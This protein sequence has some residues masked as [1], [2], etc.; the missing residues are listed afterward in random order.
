MRSA[1]AAAVPPAAIRLF[2]KALETCG[3]KSLKMYLK[4]SSLGLN[5]SQGI[6]SRTGVISVIDTQTLSILVNLTVAVGANGLQRPIVAPNGRLYVPHGDFGS[7]I[8]V[9]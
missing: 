2:L 7:L 4:A 3:Q 5:C 1:E 6:Q 8:V 9:E